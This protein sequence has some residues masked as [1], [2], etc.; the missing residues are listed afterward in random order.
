MGARY[1][2]NRAVNA[3]YG[4]RQ[5]TRRY[6]N[7]SLTA[8]GVPFAN[9]GTFQDEEEAAQHKALWD[10]YLPQGGN[11]GP[12]GMPISSV[13]NSVIRAMSGS[14]EPIARQLSGN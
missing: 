8:L 6:P 7:A 10:R 3:G 12:M 9:R 13:A 11:V 14:P 2:G 1:V 5:L 4:A